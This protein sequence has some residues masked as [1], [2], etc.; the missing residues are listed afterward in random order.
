ML[1]SQAR[2]PLAV[3]VRAR[4]RSMRRPFHPSHGEGPYRLPRD[5]HDRLTTALASFKNRESAYALAVF[6]ARYHSAPGKIVDAFPIDRRA[7]ADRPDL[8][9]TEDRIRGAIRTLETIGFLDRAITSGSTHRKTG[10]GELHRKPVLFRLGSDY[11]PAF[12][13]ANRRA[14]AARGRHSGERRALVPSAPQKASTV[15]FR[16]SPLNSPKATGVAES[17]VLMGEIRKESG[18][19]PQASE[20]NPKLEAALDRLLQG[21][22]QSRGG[23]GADGAR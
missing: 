10:D 5:A 18:L 7:L 8:G 1:G 6:I 14:T 22:R 23:S 16:A 20:P 15:D 11:A 17:T 9:L 13:A 4:V 12:I 19:P 2:L 3:P 21:I